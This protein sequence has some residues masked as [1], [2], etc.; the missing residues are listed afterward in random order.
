MPDLESKLRPVS[1]GLLGPGETLEGCCVATQVSLFKGRMVVLVVTP[2]RL[3]VQGLTRRFEPDGEP[4]SLTPD[5]IAQASA[6]GGGGRW[7]TIESIVM[8]RASVAVKLRTVDG[9]KLKLMLMRGG[10]PLGG[11]EIQRSGLAALGAWFARAGV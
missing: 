2:E 10:G 8:D 7:A 4:L 9:E 1:E 3:I 11:G 5:R 6:E